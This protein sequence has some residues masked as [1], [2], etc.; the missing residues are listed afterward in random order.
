[1]HRDIT[2][3]I[4][5]TTCP[6]Q[7]LL[8]LGS[9]SELGS[10]DISR[11]VAMTWNSHIWT[12]KVTI[13]SSSYFQYKYLLS[14]HGNVTWEQGHNRL[15]DLLS[16]KE[17]LF[18]D[19]WEA[20]RFDFFIYAA[21]DP[22]QR[23]IHVT[24]TPKALGSWVKTRPLTLDTEERRLRTGELK[25]CWKTSLVI[26]KFE[27][28]QGFEYRYL[29]LNTSTGTAIWER[30]PN[31]KAE[32]QTDS[33]GFVNSSFELFDENFV[34]TFNFHKI[35]TFPLY[36]G[37]YP[38]SKDDVEALSRAGVTAVLNVQTDVDILHRKINLE[39]MQMA[40]QEAG[41]LQVRSP[42]EDFN[43]ESLRKNLPVATER[44]KEL[45]LQGH[46]VFVHC[47]AGMGRAPAVVIAFLK[48]GL[49]LSYQDARRVVYESRPFV[50]PNEGVLR[51]LL[52]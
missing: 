43:G 49:E 47:T 12:A 6:G 23:Q 25:R 32:Y 30:E 11:A 48:L 5:F 42:I 4:P 8:V 7:T 36:L 33:K 46:S 17:N 52:A 35:G 18:D 31:R 37:P 26:P 9:I 34:V 13:T 16:L 10:W 14:E 51:E 50:A 15:G 29:E 19:Y 24:G 44:L 21:V 27:Y 2:F 40:F 3:K 38:Q 20:Y 22:S 1:M 39:E 45:H 41:I 28:Q